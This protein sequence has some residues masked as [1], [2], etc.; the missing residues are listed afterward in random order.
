MDLRSQMLVEEANRDGMRRMWDEG[1]LQREGE[2][3]KEETN[4]KG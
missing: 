4:R 1:N 3:P 2:T